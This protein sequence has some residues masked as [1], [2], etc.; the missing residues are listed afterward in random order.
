M[1]VKELI[2]LLQEENPESNVYGVNWEIGVTY[3]ISVGRDD[4]DMG[5]D[6]YIEVTNI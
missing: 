3:G 1:K 2:S 4:E 5:D 6:V